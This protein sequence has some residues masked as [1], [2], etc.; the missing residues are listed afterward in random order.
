MG[1]CVAHMI[2]SVRHA[3]H[4]LSLFYNE[5]QFQVLVDISVTNCQEVSFKVHISKIDGQYF[6]C[7]N[8]IDEMK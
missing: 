5:T 4:K 1:Y 8:V 3:I 7:V 2:R 6:E